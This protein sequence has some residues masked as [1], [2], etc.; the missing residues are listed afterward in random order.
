MIILIMVMMV[1]LAY[2]ASC[3]LLLHLLPLLHQVGVGHHLHLVRHVLDRLLVVTLK[4]H[5]FT[6][7]RVDCDPFILCFSFIGFM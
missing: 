1:I 5:F 7:C 4:F 2:G 6:F 3:L